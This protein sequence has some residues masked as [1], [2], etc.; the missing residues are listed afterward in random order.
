MTD[1]QAFLGVIPV[2]NIP[3][4]ENYF[5]GRKLKAILDG[6][7]FEGFAFALLRNGQEISGPLDKVTA[8]HMVLPGNAR[9][10]WDKELVR[11][12]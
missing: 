3:H 2:K 12:E 10:A 7:E 4:L 11:G 1:P 5:F 9:A 6:Q 8:V